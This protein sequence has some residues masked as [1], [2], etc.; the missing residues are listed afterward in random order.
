MKKLLIAL[1][2]VFIL[3]L[4]W[5]AYAGSVIFTKNQVKPVPNDV[6]TPDNA[7][8]TGFKYNGYP[9]VYARD[10]VAMNRNYLGQIVLTKLPTGGRVRIDT[11]GQGENSY[12]L[13]FAN[14]STRNTNPAMGMANN[15]VNFQDSGIIINTVLYKYSGFTPYIISSNAGTQVVYPYWEIANVFE[16]NETDYNAFVSLLNT[17]NGNNKVFTSVKTQDTQIFYKK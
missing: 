12:N 2:A 4:P 3:S 10:A 8:W 6:P 1:A 9:S 17:W 16:L 15:A 7:A 13:A 5:T 11:T 14:Y